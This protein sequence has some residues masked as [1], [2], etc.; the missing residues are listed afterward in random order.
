MGKANP[1]NCQDINAGKIPGYTGD[2]SANQPN[3]TQPGPGC[4][5]SQHGITIGGSHLRVLVRIQV[6][7]RDRISSVTTKYTIKCHHHEYHDQHV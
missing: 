6:G 7:G 1:P 5:W 2:Q 3:P 4:E